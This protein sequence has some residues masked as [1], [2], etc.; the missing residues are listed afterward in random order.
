MLS[1]GR[2]A[3]NG[4][5][6]VYEAAVHKL[7]L[8]VKPRGFCTASVPVSSLVLTEDG[9]W[10]LSWNAKQHSGMWGCIITDLRSQDGC[11]RQRCQK[12]TGMEGRAATVPPS[13]ICLPGP[14]SDQLASET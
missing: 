11:E 14:Q 4:V 5:A 13:G 10:C 8:Q 7:G 12:A 2:S 1:G 6:V 9:G 3:G